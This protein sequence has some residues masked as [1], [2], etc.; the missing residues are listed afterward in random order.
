MSDATLARAIAEASRDAADR[1]A[2]APALH[3]A[4]RDVNGIIRAQAARRR[5]HADANFARLFRNG[6]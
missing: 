1:I 3:K 5:D 2:R 4:E 6:A